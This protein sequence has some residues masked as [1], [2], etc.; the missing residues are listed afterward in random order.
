MTTIRMIDIAVNLTDGMFKGIY[1]GKKY[2]VADIVAVLSRARSAGV[3]RIIV[4]GGFLEESKEA[5][6]IAE[7]DARL[8]CMVDVHPTRCKV[9]VD[10]LL[11]AI[12][13]LLNV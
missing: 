10:T 12:L 13:K 1:N 9:A 5:L 6:A 2:H 3:D 7:T 8:F 4:T 11:N